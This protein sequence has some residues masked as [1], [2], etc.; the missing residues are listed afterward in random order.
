MTAERPVGVYVIMLAAA[1]AAARLATHHL[2]RA[3]LTEV[4]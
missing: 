1:S 2:R 4:L 3:A